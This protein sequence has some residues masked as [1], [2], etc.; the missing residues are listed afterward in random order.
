VPLRVGSAALDAVTVTGSD[1]GT[2]AGARKSTLPE[3]G[4]VGA[5]HG[6]VAS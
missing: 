4:P 6:T 5:M 2:T 3:A 1:V